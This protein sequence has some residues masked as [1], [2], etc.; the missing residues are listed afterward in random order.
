MPSELKTL[1]SERRTALPNTMRISNKRL[2]RTKTT[3]LL[4]A[5]VVALIR[6]GYVESFLVVLPQSI[7]PARVT[8]A[9]GLHGLK[10]S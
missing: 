8:L 10:T 3:S 9:R 6:E 2:S 1:S 7:K 5:I 4:E